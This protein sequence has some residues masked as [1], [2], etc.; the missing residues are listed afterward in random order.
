M[1]LEEIKLAIAFVILLGTAGVSSW[2]TYQI[3]ATK[4]KDLELSYAQANEK[5]VKTALEEQTR[6]DEVKTQVAL[7]DAQKQRQLVNQTRGQLNN[8]Q[9][10]I[11]NTCITFGT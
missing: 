10:Y 1:S 11:K 4:Y 5:A 7:E 6:L 2:V 9:K 8:V 3:D